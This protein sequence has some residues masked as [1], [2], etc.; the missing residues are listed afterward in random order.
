MP[1][2]PPWKR[3]DNFSVLSHQR[4]VDEVNEVHHKKP[5]GKQEVHNSP[6]GWALFDW[7]KS[8]SPSVFRMVVTATAAAPD[9]VLAQ[10]WDGT[11]QGGTDIPVRVFWM[12]EIG[13]EMLVAR[14]VGGTDAIYNSL[15]VEYQD[16]WTP[17][18]LQYDGMTL[19]QEGGQWVGAFTQAPA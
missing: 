16:L 2:I 3:P 4:I 1:M 12:R 13:E 18:R 7:T 9:T 11:T 10:R 19:T 5:V 8:A 15:P 6:H 17:P 14:P